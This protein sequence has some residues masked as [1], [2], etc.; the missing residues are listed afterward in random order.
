MTKYVPKISIAGENSLIIHLSEKSDV[1]VADRVQQISALVRTY[2]STDLI[3]LIPSYA[4]I[5]VIYDNFK[6][7][8]F[9]VS[10]VLRRTI[11][12]LSLIHI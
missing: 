2:L 9:N 4:S 1:V 10:K 6:T 3:D 11:L 7:D 8:H 12:E 5:L